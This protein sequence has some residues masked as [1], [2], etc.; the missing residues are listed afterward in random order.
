MA[1]TVG[2]ILIRKAGP[3]EEE[4]LASLKAAG[5]PVD[6]PYAPVYAD[7]YRERRRNNPGDDPLPERS[8][9]ISR[10]NPGDIIA[11][12]SAGCLAITSADARQAMIRIV[13]QQGGGIRLVSEGKLLKSSPAV[14]D[15]FRAADG[16]SLEVKRVNAAKA[17]EG[18]LESGNLGAA[19]A[20]YTPADYRKAKAIWNKRGMTVAE[21]VEAI[22]REVGKPISQ[23]ML[24]TK[25]RKGKAAK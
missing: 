11:V 4:Q 16:V 21:K 13:E 7:R 15:W 14:A 18:R 22:H 3:T 8:H 2:Y 1:R 17:R 12:H 19:T 10:L 5:V 20:K 23:R 6:Q 9:M 24:Y 25:F